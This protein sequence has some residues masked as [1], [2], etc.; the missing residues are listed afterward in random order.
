MIKKLKSL[1]SLKKGNSVLIKIRYRIENVLRNNLEI[2]IGDSL[3][4]FLRWQNLYFLTAFLTFQC[5][6][7][8]RVTRDLCN[9]QYIPLTNH[10]ACTFNSLPTNINST[11]YQKQPRLLSQKDLHHL[12]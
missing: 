12:Q 3:E 4:T 1:K 5:Y 11:S 10:G 9:L 8:P 6:Q 7:R 2:K